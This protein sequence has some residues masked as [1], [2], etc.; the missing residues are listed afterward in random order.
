MPI[1][2]SSGLALLER[3]FHALA[4]EIA[5]LPLQIA[6]VD[7]NSGPEALKVYGEF[8]MERVALHRINYGITDGINA[9]LFDLCK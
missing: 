5:Y 3:K 8:E 1:D 9:L 4:F 2:L 7:N 6:W